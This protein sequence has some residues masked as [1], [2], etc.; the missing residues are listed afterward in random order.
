MIDYHVLKNWPFGVVRQRYDQRDVMLYALGCGLGADPLDARQL[1][2]VYEKHLKVMPSMAAVLGTPGSW[3]SLP[4]TGVTWQRVLHAQQDVRFHAL[5]PGAATVIGL[6]RV[7]HLHDRGAGKGVLAGVER[8]IRAEDGKLIACAKRIEVLRDDG[9]FA[10]RGGP[11]DEPPPRLDPLPQQR[12]SPDIE[13]LLP[14][15]AQA[16][17]IYRLSGDPNPL[18]ADPDVARAAGFGRP[19]FH[20]LGSFGMAAHAILRT[21]CDYAPEVLARLA[22]RFTAPVYPGETMRFQIWRRDAQCVRFR[23]WAEER[24]LM[25][26]DNGFAEFK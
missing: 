6:N 22:L 20:G 23:A 21:C 4:G 26:L 1:E 8:D 18:H 17:L 13:I 3:W 9:G 15:V 25:V 12:G 14:T 24:K 11:N 16:A 2:F 5:L 10:A 7:T 19:I